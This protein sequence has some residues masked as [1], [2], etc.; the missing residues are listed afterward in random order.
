MRADPTNQCIACFDVDTGIGVAQACSRALVVW[1]LIHVGVLVYPGADGG[2]SVVPVDKHAMIR[3]MSVHR[4]HVRRAR[5]TT[6]PREQGLAPRSDRVGDIVARIGTMFSLVLLVAF[7]S[8]PTLAQSDAFSVEVAVADRSPEERVDAYSRALRRVLLDNS[9]DKTLLNRDDVREALPDAEAFVETFRF[10]VPEPGTLIAADTPVTE[11]VRDTGEATGLLLVRFDRDRVLALISGDKPDPDADAP[12]GNPLARVD[13]AL[14]WLLIDDTNRAIRGTDTAAAKVR[15]RLR[16]LAG[17]GG[18]TLLFPTDETVDDS[19]SDEALRSLDVAP[20][21]SASL[22]FATDVVVIG[23]ISRAAEPALDVNANSDSPALD[24]RVRQQSG[25]GRAPR[26]GNSETAGGWVGTWSKSA[27]DAAETTTT[28]GDTL[29]D[30][31]RAGMAWLAG[32]PT[33]GQRANYVYGGS[34]SSTEGLVRIDGLGALREYAR[35]SDLLASVPG[36][37]GSWPREIS[38]DVMVFSV[39]PRSALSA[40]SSALDRAGWLRRGVP[41]SGTGLSEIARNAELVYDVVR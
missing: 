14:L 36:V 22:R 31:L 37:S 30:V 3:A 39:V 26:P 7:P 18:V 8:A 34:G 25:P 27:Q 17:G 40:V 4:C 9:G 12:D 1:G 21:R 5:A 2:G 19:I 38:G 41:S 32:D 15:D 28:Q 11:R 33:L 24:S 16:E 35:V 6:V 20:V 29:D 23:H 13:R 10:R